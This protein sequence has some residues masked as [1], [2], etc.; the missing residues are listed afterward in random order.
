MFLDWFKNFPIRIAKAKL[1]YSYRGE[2]DNWFSQ[3]V[4]FSLYSLGGNCNKDMAWYLTGDSEVHISSV[5]ELC[6]WLFSCEYISWEGQD[7]KTLDWQH[8]LD[9]EK[10][11]KGNCVDFS[12]WAWR[13]LIELDVKVELFAGEWIRLGKK[14]QYFWVVFESDGEKYLIDTVSKDKEKMLYRLESVKNIY[15]PW[16]SVDNDMECR[17]YG[18]YCAAMKEMNNWDF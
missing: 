1:L 12:L 8:P 18:G 14:K 4:G 13:R 16:A 15:I 11:K 6:E 3:V 9:F 5:K 7:R 17:L 2:D 10:E